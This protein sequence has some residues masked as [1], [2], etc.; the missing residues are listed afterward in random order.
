MC[1]VLSINNIEFGD[2]LIVQSYVLRDIFPG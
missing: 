1:K 2:L